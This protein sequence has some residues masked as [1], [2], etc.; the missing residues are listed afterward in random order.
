MNTLTK[1]NGTK[2]KVTSK[3]KVGVK[4][5]PRFR[6]GTKQKNNFL[7]FISFKKEDAF[8]KEK[9]TEITYYPIPKY[10]SKRYMIRNSIVKTETGSLVRIMNLNEGRILGQMIS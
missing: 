9:I 8:V 10:R 1:S 5:S 2:L 3:G 4:I 7:C 6:L